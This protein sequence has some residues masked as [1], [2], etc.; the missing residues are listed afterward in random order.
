MPYRIVIELSEA[1]VKTDDIRIIANY[2][3][4]VLETMGYTYSVDCFKDEMKVMM[5]LEDPQKTSSR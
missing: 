2:L 5:G 4:E 3:A 1:E